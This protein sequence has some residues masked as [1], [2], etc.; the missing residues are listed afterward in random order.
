MQLTLKRWLRPLVRATRAR[1]IAAALAVAAASAWSACNGDKTAVRCSTLSYQSTGQPVPARFCEPTR[2][3]ASLPAVLY[4]HPIGGPEEVPR[5]LFTN[6]ARA[7]IATLEISYFA[8]TPAPGPNPRSFGYVYENRLDAEYLNA[9]R[10]WPGVIA[11]GVTFLQQQPRIDPERIGVAGYSLGAAMALKTAGTETRYKALAELS[12]FTRLDGLPQVS[13]FWGDDLPTRAPAFPP[14]LI[15]HGQRDDAVP[16]SE[17]YAIRDVLTA[18]GK[19]PEIHVYPRNGHF[20]NGADA[21]D[22][23]DRLVAFFSRHLA[24]R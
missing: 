21:R 16:V 14:V 23:R 7:G 2:A 6:L 19:T 15:L 4:L 3:A 1:R 20:W 17:A 5:G 18:A 10:V 13:R 12:G 11:D 22:A 24:A 8:L 9:A